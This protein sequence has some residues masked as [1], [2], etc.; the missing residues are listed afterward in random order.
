VT[1]PTAERVAAL[2]VL[3]LEAALSGHAGNGARLPADLAW[4]AV[5]DAV[6]SPGT[7]ARCPNLRAVL[8]PEVAAAVTRLAGR[9]ISTQDLEVDHKIVSVSKPGAAVSRLAGQASEQAG[10]EAASTLVAPAPP[11]RHLSTT[12]AAAALGITSHGVADACRR[13]T[14]PAVHDG[15]GRWVIAAADLEEYRRTHAKIPG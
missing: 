1:A 12:D 15:D 9:D 7:A 4:L 11:P 2:R 10:S 13:G 8:P 3:L 6:R 5:H 14:L